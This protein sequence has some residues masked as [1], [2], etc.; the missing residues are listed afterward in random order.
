MKTSEKKIAYD[1]D[2]IRS[3][4]ESD[5]WF[6]E[7][8]IRNKRKQKTKSKNKKRDSKEEYLNE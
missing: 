2:S 4:Y 1:H 8:K 6:D 7:D 5:D 3:L